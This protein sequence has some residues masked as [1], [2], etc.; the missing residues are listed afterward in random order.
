MSTGT[1]EPTPTELRRLADGLNLAPRTRQLLAKAEF[2]LVGACMAKK[3]FAYFY[4]PLT[5]DAARATEENRTRELR[6]DDVDRAR[7]EGFGATD[8]RLP[9]ADTEHREPAYLATLSPARRDAWIRTLH[10]DPAQQI[11]KVEV[12][13]VGTLEA[14]TTGCFASARTEL[15]GNYEK[16]VRADAFVTS[17]YLPVNEAVRKQ[18]SYARSTQRWSA[19]MRA[20]SYRFADPAEA[21]RSADATG[22]GPAAVQ[23]AVASAACDRKTG[24]SR[25]HRELFQQQTLQWVKEHHAQALDFGLLNRQAAG[26]AAA[27]TVAR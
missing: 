11:I 15:Y 2:T 23:L 25:T 16:W 21:A 22:D 1:P 7:R 6:G 3:G 8:P 27:L 9:A 26:R 24:R 19:C 14:P 18:P 4:G 5:L 17:R 12:R 10:G 13:G 20:N